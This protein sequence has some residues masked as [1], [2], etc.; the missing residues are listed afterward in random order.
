M[1]SPITLHY[2]DEFNERITIDDDK[3]FSR[4]LEK[5]IYDHQKKAIVGP[6]VLQLIVASPMV[7]G[8]RNYVFADSKSGF[9]PEKMCMNFDYCLGE[10]I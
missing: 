3:T 2:I 10:L 5:A 8:I 7:K 9:F 6:I 4:A 1:R